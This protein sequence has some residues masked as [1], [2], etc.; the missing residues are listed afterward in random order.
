MK[1]CTII[2]AEAYPLH[3]NLLKSVKHLSFQH[4]QEVT[5]ANEDLSVIVK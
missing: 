2:L 3:G 1:A 5:L 4:I